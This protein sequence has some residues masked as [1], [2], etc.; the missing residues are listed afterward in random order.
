MTLIGPN[1]AGKTTL[2]RLMLGVTKPSSGEIRRRDGLVIGYVPQ[3]FDLDRAVPMTVNRFLTLSGTDTDEAGLEAALTE[4]GAEK[5][6]VSGNLRN[7]P[8]ASCSAY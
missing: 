2:V 7:F 6:W 5:G 4:V 1:G 8:G 3:R